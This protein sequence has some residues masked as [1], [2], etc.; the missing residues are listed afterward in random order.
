MKNFHH[1]SSLALDQLFDFFETDWP[2]ADA[3]LGEDVLTVTL[4]TG[5]HYF[6]NKHGVT[7]QIWVASPFTGAHHFAY[8]SGQW[9]CTRTQRELYGVI[10][11]E[12]DAHVS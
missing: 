4:P 8:T 12:R 6:I 7:H 10:K 11:G 5:K 2:A 1:L 3:E 9:L